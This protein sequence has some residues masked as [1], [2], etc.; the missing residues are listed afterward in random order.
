M[1]LQPRQPYIDTYIYIY[2]YN[3]Y[4]SWVTLG[5]G[6]LLTLRLLTSY[7]RDFWSELTVE[8]LGT[9]DLLSG[10]YPV[11]SLALNV[12]NLSEAGRSPAY[13]LHLRI[14]SELGIEEK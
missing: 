6:D 10:N 1:G 5:I 3:I 12:W 9:F 8:G 2:I 13:A 7:P 11:T 14:V 4:L